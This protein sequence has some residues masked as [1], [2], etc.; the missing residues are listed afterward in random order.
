M[1]HFVL[2]WHKI[3]SI[4]LI[5]RILWNLIWTT[6]N[7]YGAWFNMSQQKAA[8]NLA[9]KYTHEMRPESYENLNYLK[10]HYF[11]RHTWGHSRKNQ[12][13]GRCCLS[14][15]DYF[16]SKTWSFFRK[17]FWQAWTLVRSFGSGEMLLSSNCSLKVIYVAYFPKVFQNQ[18][19]SK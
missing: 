5:Y 3:Y 16:W 4:W 1:S 6:V 9:F 12:H 8:V 11:P 19:V 15:E 7:L 14:A 13:L 18:L 10:L 17:N 2:V